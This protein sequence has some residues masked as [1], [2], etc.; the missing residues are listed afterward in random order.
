MKFT[1]MLTL[2]GIAVST[3]CGVAKALGGCDDPHAISTSA[4]SKGAKLRMFT[5]PLSRRSFPTRLGCLIGEVRKPS[6][7]VEARHRVEA[8]TATSATWGRR[9]IIVMTLL[10]SVVTCER[11]V[12]HPGE[13]SLMMAIEEPTILAG[14]RR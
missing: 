12:W 7:P 5:E 13:G 14:D 3:E 2:S 4:S 1:V 9:V 11:E 10:F 8:R 6:W